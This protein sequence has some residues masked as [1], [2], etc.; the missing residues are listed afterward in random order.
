[1]VSY[2]ITC[3]CRHP[4]HDEKPYLG[5]VVDVDEMLVLGCH[6]GTVVQPFVT[7]TNNKENSLVYTCKPMPMLL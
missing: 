3:G 2:S 4:T 5:C 6:P 1:M 7:F